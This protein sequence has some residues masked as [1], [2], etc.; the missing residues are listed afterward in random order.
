MAEMSW[1]FWASARGQRWE[2]FWKSFLKRLWKNH[3]R[4]KENIYF[5]KLRDWSPF[6][7]RSKS[8]RNFPL[9]S[10]KFS[11][12][13]LYKLTKNFGFSY[14][15][16]S[17]SSIKTLFGCSNGRFCK[18]VLRLSFRFHYLDC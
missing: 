7:L 10:P 18:G 12:T 3:I 1:K 4:T 6:F 13:L 17:I 16:C 15:R 11:T 8:F 2:K 9:F 14:Q 5:R